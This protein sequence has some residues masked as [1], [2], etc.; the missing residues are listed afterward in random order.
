MHPDQLFVD[1]LA[2]FN[3]FRIIKILGVIVAA[4]A[5]IFALE[6][7][8][9]WLAEKAPGRKRLMILST[10]PVLRLLIMFMAVVTVIPMIIKPSVQNL[11]A[12]FGAV[13]LAVG[14]AFKD[15]ASNLIAG[16][17][18]IY[19]QPYR[20]GDWVKIDG[21]Y[22]E[23]KSMGM[24]A[25]KMVTADDTVVI[26]PHTKIWDTNIY[27]ANDGKRELQCTA[28]FFIH[29]PHDAETVRRKL[30]DVALT[31]TCLQ[32]KKP[33]IVTVEEKIGST[34]YRLKAYPVDG[35][36]QFRF[37]TDLTIRG[38]AAL[39]ELGVRTGY[40]V[41]RYSMTSGI[42]EKGPHTGITD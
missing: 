41:C 32:P 31:S 17:V 11:V 20:P 33:V 6:R 12:V 18:A 21:A 22:G 5:A 27:N 8:F 34:R 42:D 39:S 19:E 16:I 38:K 35:R 37:V 40:P 9:P 3:M 14:F 4:W 15:Y 30:Y 23:I 28:N 36:D 1:L 24:R 25:V 10:V 7:V 29:M 13:G 2:E 26:I